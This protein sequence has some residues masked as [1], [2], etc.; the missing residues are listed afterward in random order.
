M[1]EL[2]TQLRRCPKAHRHAPLPCQAQVLPDALL[3]LWVTRPAEEEGYGQATMW[4][5]M[6]CLSARSPG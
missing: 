3:V 4:G 2:S 6:G 1:P 5:P